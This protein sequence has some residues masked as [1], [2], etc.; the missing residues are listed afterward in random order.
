MF[1]G[2]WFGRTT[3]VDVVGGEL[4]AGGAVTDSLDVTATYRPEVLAY[5]ARTSTWLTHTGIVEALK[6][7]ATSKNLRVLQVQLQG[8]PDQQYDIRSIEGA[9]LIQR[10]PSRARSTGRGA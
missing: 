9:I 1:G 8:G 7:L 3:F 2:G 6:I 5:E 10:R 4:G